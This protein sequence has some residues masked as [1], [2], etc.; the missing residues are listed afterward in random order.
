MVHICRL[1]FIQTTQRWD[2]KGPKKRKRT[3]DLI[4]LMLSTDSW[5]R[6]WS[7]GETGVTAHHR[8]ELTGRHGKRN[9]ARS[10]MDYQVH[11]EHHTTGQSHS[12]APCL[13]LWKIDSPACAII[14]IATQGR[15]RLGFFASSLWKDITSAVEVGQISSPSQAGSH[16]FT[17][18]NDDSCN[19]SITPM[20]PYK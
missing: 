7:A 6:G 5:G 16:H 14:A 1:T 17:L 3:A 20:W 19:S 12:S 9:A 8:C 13:R 2:L 15:Q 18:W 4:R 10:Q 11:H